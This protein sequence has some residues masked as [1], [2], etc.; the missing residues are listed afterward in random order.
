M[1]RYWAR[2]NLANVVEQVAKIEG[3]NGKNDSECKDYLRAIYKKD[4][5]KEGFKG[6][7]NN[8]KGNLPTVGM[9]YLPE[10]DVFVFQKPYPSWI[11]SSDKKSWVSPVPYP[12]TYTWTSDQAISA[13]ELTIAET[14]YTWD[15]DTQSWI[16]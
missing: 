10:E 15:E 11:L 16:S 13:E 1:A 8:P 7:V 3:F 2:L 14:I 5:W 4:N 9:Q 12:V 6:T